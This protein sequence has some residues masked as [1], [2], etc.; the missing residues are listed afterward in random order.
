MIPT[1]PPSNAHSLDHCTIIYELI[2][3]T[4][5]LFRVSVGIQIQLRE[6]T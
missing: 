5:Q 1:S 6:R 2:K 3:V 4:F